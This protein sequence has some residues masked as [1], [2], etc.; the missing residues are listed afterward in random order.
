MSSALHYSSVKC[1]QCGCVVWNLG[2]WR[3]RPVGC[4]SGSK[5]RSRPLAGCVADSRPVGGG[6]LAGSAADSC[7]LVRCR[8]VG[9]LTGPS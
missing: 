3:H 7:P 8:D 2:R 9:G 5:M 1:A 4:G 6:M